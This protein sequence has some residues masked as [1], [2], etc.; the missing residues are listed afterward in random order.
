MGGTVKV[1]HPHRAVPGQTVGPGSIQHILPLCTKHNLLG[2]EDPCFTSAL[3]SAIVTCPQDS[4][5]CAMEMSRSSCKECNEN[6][7]Q[8]PAVKQGGFKARI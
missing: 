3:L 8:N 4:L 2:L 5:A 1:T 6:I 7:K